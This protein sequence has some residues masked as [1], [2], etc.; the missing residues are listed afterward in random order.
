MKIK[1]GEI[2]AGQSTEFFDRTNAVFMPVRI[3]SPDREGC[4]PIA[5]ARKRP[6]DVSFKPLSESTVLDEFGMPL[7]A[8]VLSH[9]QIA[10]L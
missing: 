5:V 4:A 8:L 6:V 3:A 2:T 1:L 10:M 9:E 7:N